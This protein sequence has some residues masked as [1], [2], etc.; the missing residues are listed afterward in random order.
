MLQRQ[1]QAYRRTEGQLEGSDCCIYK[2]AIEIDPT[3]NGGNDLRFTNS[4][5]IS[6]Y[7]ELGDVDAAVELY[8]ISPSQF[9]FKFEQG[10]L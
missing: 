4:E 3:Q 5:L 9:E 8:E 2:K 10:I 1:A 6:L 7:I